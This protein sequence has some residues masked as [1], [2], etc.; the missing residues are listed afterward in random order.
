MKNKKHNPKTVHRP[1][2]KY[3]HGIEVGPD[4][5]WLYAS[6]QVGSNAKGKVVRGF[7]A[8]CDRA[9]RNMI[10]VLKAADMGPED[11][12]MVTVYLTRTE[13]I[14]AYRQVRDRLLGRARPAS[15]LVVISQLATPE[16][17]VEVEGTA[18]KS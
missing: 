5:R 13:D 3:T 2:G 18:A 4:A 6:G 17:L 9:Y 8:Q 11:L 1:L 16:L 14:P 7:N 15:T 10:A 12:V